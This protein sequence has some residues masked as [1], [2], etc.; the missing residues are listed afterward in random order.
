MG[1]KKIDLTI[2][3]NI[4]CNTNLKNTVYQASMINLYTICLSL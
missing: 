3:E 2:D 1:E 4:E